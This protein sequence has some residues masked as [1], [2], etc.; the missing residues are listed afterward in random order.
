M[1]E[2]LLK[3]L[4]EE[5]KKRARIGIQ[6]LIL[7]SVCIVTTVVGIELC[8]TATMWVAVVESVILIPYGSVTVYKMIQSHKTENVILSRLKKLLKEESIE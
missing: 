5:E 6:F 8:K 7:A 2:E 3:Q 1:K 4:K